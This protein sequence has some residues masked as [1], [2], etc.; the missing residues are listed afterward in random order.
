MLGLVVWR[1]IVLG[2]VVLGRIV[3]GLVVLGLL[4]PVRA[5]TMFCW[6][7]CHQIGNSSLQ[8]ELDL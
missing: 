3:L 4:E 6:K 7:P 5:V 2:L 8:L 1:R